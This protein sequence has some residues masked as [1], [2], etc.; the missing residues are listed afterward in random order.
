MLLYRGCVQR[1]YF[2][3]HFKTLAVS[4][5]LFLL[6]LAISFLIQACTFPLLH[7]ELDWGT[8]QNKTNLILPCPPQDTSLS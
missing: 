2:D 5:Y 8:K 7:G 6:R 3:I 1:P 4:A